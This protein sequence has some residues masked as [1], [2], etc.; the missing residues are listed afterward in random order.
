MNKREEACYQQIKCDT[1]CAA[2][3]ESIVMDSDDKGNVL[4]T[5]II[6]GGECSDDFDHRRVMHD[7]F[8]RDKIPAAVRNKHLRMPIN[9]S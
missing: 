1:F 9:L 2:V 8:P 7:N 4:S 6:Y 5:E 3:N